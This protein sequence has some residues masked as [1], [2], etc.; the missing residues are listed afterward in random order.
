MPALRVQALSGSIYTSGMGW[1]DRTSSGVSALWQTRDDVGTAGWGMNQHSAQ[2]AD[3]VGGR[4]EFRR[5]RGRH[6]CHA[7]PC[8]GHWPDRPQYGAAF[9]SD[10]RPSG[11][12]QM[13]ETIVASVGAGGVT[14]ALLVWI[15][16]EWLSER[17]K[18]SISAEYARRLEEYKRELELRFND[19]VRL[20]RLYE[21]LAMSLEDIYGTMPDQ[22][23]KKMAISVHKMFALL[24]LYAPDDVY[25]R[26]KDTFYSRDGKTVYAR[27]F[28]PPV[29]HA[30]RKSLFG[31]ETNLDPGDLV[32]NL[33]TRPVPQDGAATGDA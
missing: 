7:G 19:Q 17:L 5:L 26:V 22:D 14:G 20:R 10:A 23:P 28:R 32:D 6:M 11:D 30:L 15:L 2:Q 8:W 29:Y 21:D 12:R 3:L 27:D 9:E 1:T 4:C 31:A 33:E 25:R 18:Q 24:A 13:I 16:R